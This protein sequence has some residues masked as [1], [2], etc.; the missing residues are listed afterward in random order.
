[1]HKQ[2]ICLNGEFLLVGEKIFGTDNR[3]YVYGDALFETIHCMGTEAQFLQKHWERLA[4]GMSMLKMKPG[5]SLNY[6]VL[7]RSIVKLLNRNRIF[8]GA[9]VR[10]V[11]C[12]KPG[13]LY[14]PATNSVS[15]TLESSVLEHE[16]YT[17]NQKGIIADVFDAVHKP[18]NP[19]S[20]FKTANA[21]IYVLAGIFRQENQLGDCF[22]LNQFGRIA[23]TNHSNL[24]IYLDDQL[25]TPPLSEGCVA[26]TMRSTIL[27]LARESGYKVLEKPV[28]ETNLLDAEE[29]FITNAIQGIQWIGSYKDK[30]YFNFVARKLIALLNQY[31]FRKN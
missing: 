24:F 19:L 30:R 18:I 7:A 15:W 23:E 14:A 2:Y 4:D 1:M 9:R 5:D 20:G 13:G 17:L 12:R 16:H 28:I 11:V 26:G 22:I 21:L 25:I 3:G 6:E 31:A 8:K 10:L 27:N 29:V